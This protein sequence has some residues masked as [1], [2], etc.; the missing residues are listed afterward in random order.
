MILG[1]FSLHW[2]HRTRREIPLGKVTEYATLTAA[3]DA[4]KTIG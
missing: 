4:T 1:G 3:Y 2:A